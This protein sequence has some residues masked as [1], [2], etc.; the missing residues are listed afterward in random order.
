MIRDIRTRFG[1]WIVGGIIGLIAFVFVFSGVFSPDPMVSGAAAGSVNGTPITQ[2]EFN[3]ALRQ[4][5]SMF[6]GMNFSAEQLAQFGIYDSIFKNLVNRQLLIQAAQDQ[7]IIISD[8]EVRDAIRQIPVFQED[9][10]FDRKKYEDLLKANRMNPA[11]FETSIRSDLMVQ[12]WQDFFNQSVHASKKEIETEYL[13]QNNQRNIQFVFLNTAFTP[14][15]LKV[16]EKKVK[17]FLSNAENLKQAQEHYNDRK[18]T[19]FKDKPFDEA[20][21]V[22]A[23]QKIR[24]TLRNQRTDE[25]IALG[26]KIEKLLDG[27]KSSERKVNQ[28]LKKNKIEVEYTE[29][30]PRTS[31]YLPVIGFA[32]QLLSDAFEVPSP[33]YRK[34]RGKAKTYQVTK[35][36]VVAAL[37]D[38]QLGDVKDL[39]EEKIEVLRSKIE[40][41]KQGV[42]FQQW[43][44]ELTKKAEILKNE[45]FFKQVQQG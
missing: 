26:K 10:K 16:D 8:E 4:R 19:Q 9:G 41:Q 17:A 14:D 31:K 1:P 24:E 37:A 36:I 18:E 22:I 27:T 40:Q 7:G 35:G 6:E 30:I 33:I 25:M 28:L 45:E 3:R 44:D 2:G 15:E 23:A 11:S 38:R 5:M 20:K 43:L 42:I 39:D 21:K 12:Y 34:D 32:E 29:M 13:N